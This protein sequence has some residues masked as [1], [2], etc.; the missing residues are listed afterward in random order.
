MLSAVACGIDITSLCSDYRVEISHPTA[1][2]GDSSKKSPPSSSGFEGG[3]FVLLNVHAGLGV[4]LMALFDVGFEDRWES[5]ILGD[6]LTQVAEA[7][8]SS[9]KGE[10]GISVACHNLLHPN[11]ME[12]SKT[13]DSSV[14]LSC[15]CQKR[16]ETC[17]IVQEKPKFVDVQDWMLA[18]PQARATV[19]ESLS[20]YDSKFLEELAH[21]SVDIF[22][23]I[24]PMIAVG[25]AE[26]ANELPYRLFPTEFEVVAR[27]P[28]ETSTPSERNAFVTGKF[29][30]RY[31]AFINDGLLN[32]IV[33]HV[34]E[35]ARDSYEIKVTKSPP[36]LKE[37]LKLGI[38]RF[39]GRKLV[40]GSPMSGGG[41]SGSSTPSLPPS[42]GGGE[43]FLTRKRKLVKQSDE[44]TA[45]AAATSA[46][47]AIMN[48]KAQ[49]A[50]PVA[51][52]THTL[53][54]KEESDLTAELRNILVLFVKMDIQGQDLLI[55]EN[56]PSM[57][58]VIDYPESIGF[59]KVTQAEYLDDQ[60]ILNKYQACMEIL[61]QSLRE[62]GGQL[63]QFI[64]DDK[65]TVGIGCKL[66]LVIILF[67]VHYLSYS[68]YA[69][70]S[71]RFA[72]FR[73]L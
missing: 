25:S 15:G 69:S 28:S 20:T 23:K 31:S 52:S 44:V 29:Y 46:A 70:F 53:Q 11:A 66:L 58:R 26:V 5:L 14:L 32:G 21:K 12:V 35:A 55:D 50:S 56:Q 6:P 64:V 30:D 24:R 73:K 17:F 39:P 51:P 2:A 49:I 16:T 47:T 3:D 36:N 48:T 60:R 63:R 27:S 42:K 72:R 7:E 67:L 68:S 33:R 71:L 41:G 10:L 43:S 65:G 62:N 45:T 54:G 34:H 9:N 37:I 57:N 18:K 13:D 40:L 38:D 19:S 59:A 22:E 1:K 61:V 4:G 8:S